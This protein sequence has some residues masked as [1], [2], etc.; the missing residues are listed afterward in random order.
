M[1]SHC[2]NILTHF[3]F[4]KHLQVHFFTFLSKYKVLIQIRIRYYNTNTNSNPSSKPSSSFLPYKHPYT[5]NSK[6][7]HSLL[8][9]GYTYPLHHPTTSRFPC[10]R[11]SSSIHHSWI[12]HHRVPCPFFPTISAINSI[13]HTHDSPIHRGY[14]KETTRREY[15]KAAYFSR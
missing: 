3:S 1:K 10:H 8:I 5:S 6:P 13:Y 12:D 15:H 9:R 4:E 14:R 11:L 2:E 7:Y